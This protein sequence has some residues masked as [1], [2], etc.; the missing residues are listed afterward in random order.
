MRRQGVAKKWLGAVAGVLLCLHTEVDVSAQ[1]SPAGQT[2]NSG[3][4]IVETTVE[5]TDV[6]YRDGFCL[7]CHTAIPAQGQGAMLKSD[8]NFEKICWC[9]YKV[10]PGQC[11]HPVGASLAPLSQSKIPPEYPL[12]DAKLTCITCH[13]LQPQCRQ[14]EAEKAFSK[15]K[16][17]LRGGP[18][19]KRTD[20]CFVCHDAE[21]YRRRNAHK[22]LDAF[23]TID[24][25]K[26]LYCH[27]EKPDEKRATAANVRFV[28]P[29]TALCQRC[30]VIAGTHSGNVAHVGRKPSTEALVRISRME[31]RQAV[32]LP[33]DEEGKLTCITCHNPHQRGVIPPYRR[34]AKGADERYRH[35]VPG[36]LCTECHEK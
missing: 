30:H 9:H 10:P 22:Q 2:T 5:T 17:L 36:K 7:E 33:L 15:G 21:A 3:A 29:M 26:C 4:T 1:T 8:R 23:R 18:F 27:V 6:H 28:G 25:E 35:R 13:D 24:E 19:P 14:G 31:D 12:E 16:M 11:S 32:V 34:A 20:P